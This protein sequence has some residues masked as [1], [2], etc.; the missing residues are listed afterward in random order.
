MYTAYVNDSPLR[1]AATP[2]ADAPEL[3]LRYN[4]K[5]KFLLHVVSTLEGG[6]HPA[7]ALLLTEEPDALWATFRRL[8]RLVPA[9]GGA[10]LHD[11]RLLC[12][13]R[14]GS[15]DLPKGKIDEGESERE[16]AVREVR[17]ETGLRELSVSRVLPTTYHTYRD[18]K[19]RRVLK[20]TY[21]Y[22]MRTTEERL[23]PQIEEDIE[24]ARWVPL[25][26]LGEVRAGMYASLRGIIDAVVPR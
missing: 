11:D 3:T 20:P 23:A 4:G 14:R 19:G 22:E 21:W 17:E 9:A 10:V 26:G 6:H 1:I 8:Y 16:A 18:R 12:I 2:P 13:Y 5:S 24:E 15:W 25:R 7:G